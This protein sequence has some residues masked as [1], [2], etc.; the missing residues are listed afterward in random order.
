MLPSS[1]RSRACSIACFVVFTVMAL[2]SGTEGM[3]VG[4]SHPAA[5]PNADLG[6]IVAGPDGNMWYLEITRNTIGRIT[7]DGR[8]AGQFTLPPPQRGILAM[9]P[10][11]DGN[12]WFAE[13]KTRKIGRFTWPATLTEFIV[14]GNP[15]DITVGPDRA[16]WFTEPT[17]HLIGRISLSGTIH[18]FPMFAESKRTE[19]PYPNSIALGPDGNLWFTESSI[20]D[21]ITDTVGRITPAGKITQVRFRS[22]T[23]S[24]PRFIITGPD[25]SLWFTEQYLDGSQGI[26]RMAMSGNIVHFR[27]PGGDR[28]GIPLELTIGSDGNIWFSEL[29]SKIGSI[30]P[31][32]Q[33]REFTIPGRWRDLFQGIGAGPDG[34][35]WFTSLCRNLIGRITVQG[36]VAL[37]PLAGFARDAGDNCPLM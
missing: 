25:G 18:E 27:M 33:I 29:G 28:Q 34:T 16:I 35:I 15:G 3:H 11:P 31:G 4:A 6:S 36:R 37:F 26:G 5:L 7:P 2:M 8:F 24:I 12:M 9:V 17:V 30:M 20:G 14:S 21:T 13:S 23:T 22:R 10:G 32:G 19:R 1:K